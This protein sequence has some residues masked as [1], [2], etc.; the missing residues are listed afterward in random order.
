MT[1]EGPMYVHEEE[2]SDH[3]L[4]LRDNHEDEEKRTGEKYHAC[5]LQD[6]TMHGNA[7]A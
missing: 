7:K 5:L 1:H 4:R 3:P 6:M 2:L